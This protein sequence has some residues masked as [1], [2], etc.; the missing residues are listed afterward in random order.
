MVAMAMNT[1]EVEMT[2]PS[3][4]QLRY[5]MDIERKEMPYYCS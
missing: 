3:E 2:V 1:I 4:S 5:V